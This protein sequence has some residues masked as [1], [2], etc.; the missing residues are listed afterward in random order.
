MVA[1]TRAL[2]PGAAL[3]CLFLG[4]NDAVA[5]RPLISPEI[6]PQR[7]LSAFTP[8]ETTFSQAFWAETERAF[9]LVNLT[10]GAGPRMVEMAFAQA[11]LLSDELPFNRLSE[12]E[13]RASP[14]F[15]EGLEYPENG[16]TAKAAR[17]QAERFDRRKLLAF[18]MAGDRTFLEQVGLFGVRLAALLFD[19]IALAGYIIAGVASRR[20]RVAL[21]WSAGWTVAIEAI[22]VSV[23]AS[24]GLSLHSGHAFVPR[25]LVALTA[26]AV[27]F[28]V[29]RV[30]RR[31]RDRRPS[32]V[33]ASLGVVLGYLAYASGSG[34]TG[35]SGFSH[36]ISRPIRH[37][38]LW[39][40][41]FGAAIGI[42]IT[43]FRRLS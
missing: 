40:G 35:S 21:L 18:T 34:A 15:R 27:A 25:I 20:L 17:I 12:D 31:R 42:A 37:A 30:V 26:A 3:I 4:T 43:Y 9:N 16:W 33:G 24:E 38:G 1:I 10:F 13:W 8:L 22:I 39:W 23:A 5:T 6:R 36:W 28:Q 32:A 14:H 11:E 7:L 19:P 29:A 41:L 2:I